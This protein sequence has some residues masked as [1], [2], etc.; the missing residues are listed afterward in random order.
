MNYNK[1]QGTIIALLI[2]VCLYLC[3][4]PYYKVYKEYMNWKDKYRKQ[5][6]YP[7]IKVKGELTSATYGKTEIGGW[8]IGESMIQ[9]RDRLYICG[10]DGIRTME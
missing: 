8:S 1:E 3:V 4:S 10:K 9:H 2:C 6:I 7:D 5:T